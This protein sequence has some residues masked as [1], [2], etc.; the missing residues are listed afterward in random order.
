[1]SVTLHNLQP[2]TQYFYRVGA[3]PTVRSFTTAPP[4]APAGFPF[5]VA[6]VADLGQSIV[7]HRIISHIAATDA[8]LALL[9]GDVVYADGLGARWD[10]GMRLLEPLASTR[11]LAACAGNHEVER[12]ESFLPFIA[13][14]PT[15]YTWS[16]SPTPLQY[17]FTQ[18]PVQVIVLNTYAGAAGMLRQAAWLRG[19]LGAIDREATPWVVALCHAPF[20]SSFSNKLYSKAGQPLRW[21]VEELLYAAGVDILVS[22]HVHAYERSHPVFNGTLDACGMTQLVVGDAGAYG[23]PHIGWAEPQ[24]GWS[25]FRTA[26]FGAGR[27]EFVNASHTRWTW[28]RVACGSTSTPRDQDAYWTPVWDDAADGATSCR[29]TGDTSPAGGAHHDEHWVVRDGQCANRLKG[30]PASV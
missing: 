12:G 15:P 4:P 18:G 13:R 14:F 25:A 19:V 24:P 2:D 3:S 1:M 16:G 30:K 23:G 17:T 21:A 6:V 27:L 9:A 29:T 26:T 28:S 8:R 7:S 20:Y 11:L 10:S 22:G 5:A